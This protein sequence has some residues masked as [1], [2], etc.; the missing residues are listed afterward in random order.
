MWGIP[1]IY[2]FSELRDGV[3]KMRSV[4]SNNPTS[5]H[6]Y[7]V[8]R[9]WADEYFFQLDAWKRE[10]VDFASTVRD[11]GQSAVHLDICGNTSARSLGYEHSY[12]F[13]MSTR[14]HWPVDCTAYRGDIFDKQALRDFL[15]QIEAERGKL[16]FTTFMPMAG[17]Q[18][19]TPQRSCASHR[20]VLYQRLF[21]QLEQVLLHTQVG[22]YVL[23][24]RPFQLD[25]GDGRIGDFLSR[26]PF[27][28]TAFHTAVKAWA[29]LLKCSVRGKDSIVGGNWLLK[30]DHK[31]LGPVP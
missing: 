13:S 7:R 28:Q 16:S 14:G 10:I 18:S 30:R 4:I 1:M 17:L 21:Q 27:K 25:S 5:S 12:Q 11:S 20:D 6:Y 31:S 22:G 19:Y 3:M 15:Q 2:S 29:K 26:T 9:S 24:E 8:D 23:L